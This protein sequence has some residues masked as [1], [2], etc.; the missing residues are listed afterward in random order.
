MTAR[1]KRKVRNPG[2]K[3]SRKRSN[4]HFKKRPLPM[5]DIIRTHWSKEKTLRENYSNLGLMVRLNGCTGGKQDQWIDNVPTTLKGLEEQWTE[6]DGGYM[7][8]KY[9]QHASTA[10]SITEEAVVERDKDG[11]IIGMRFVPKDNTMDN[12]E[13]TGKN[14]EVAVRELNDFAPAVQVELSESAK[15]MRSGNA[16]R[17]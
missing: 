6:L 4:A 1:Q 5:P 10:T 7:H 13:E 11:N 15:A 17:R 3:V 12:K 9:R 14:A 8:E 16:V 2:S